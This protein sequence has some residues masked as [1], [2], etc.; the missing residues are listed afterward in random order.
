M[1][2][3]TF[4]TNDATNT[5]MT[6]AHAATKNGDYADASNGLH[7]SMRNSEQQLKTTN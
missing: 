3:N 1:T 5:N 7:T 2:S 6:I 4:S